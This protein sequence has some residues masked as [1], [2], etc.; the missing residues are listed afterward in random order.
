MVLLRGSKGL[1]VP[2]LPIV[3]S[4]HQELGTP[5]NRYLTRDTR[6]DHPVYFCG[7]LFSGFRAKALFFSF[8]AEFDT[9]FSLS[10]QKKASSLTFIPHLKLKDEGTTDY[11]R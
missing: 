4:G 5:E 9:N 3:G 8:A 10:Q 7:L 11:S 1:S 6:L 2:T